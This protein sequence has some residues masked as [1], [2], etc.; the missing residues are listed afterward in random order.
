MSLVDKCIECDQY[1]HK[2]HFDFCSFH[3]EYKEMLHLNRLPLTSA[4]VLYI[5]TLTIGESNFDLRPIVEQLG[6]IMPNDNTLVFH[7]MEMAQLV[8]EIR[9]MKQVLADANTALL[10][11]QIHDTLFDTK[12]G[13]EL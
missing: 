3:P 4:R 6:W 7:N 10:R 8:T 9:A 12:H 2:G 1:A 13:D 5:A 11:A